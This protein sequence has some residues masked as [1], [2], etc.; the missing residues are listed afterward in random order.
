MKRVLIMLNKYKISED[1]SGIGLRMLEI[2]QVLARHCDVTICSNSISDLN[3]KGVRFIKCDGVEL[4]RLIDNSDTVVSTDLPNLEMLLYSYKMGKQ[5]IIENSIPVEHLFYNEVVLS[6]NPDNTYCTL[7]LQFYFQLMI[8]DVVIARSFADEQTLVP[9]L[10]FAGRINSYTYTNE[11]QLGSLICTIPIGFNT[12]SDE[13][14][15]ASRLK[16]NACYPKCDFLW[17]GGVWD[18]LNPQTVIDALK[19][20]P[21]TEYPSVGF[22]YNPPKDQFIKSYDA[23]TRRVEENQLNNVKFYKDV[24]HTERD[25][26]IEGSKALICIGKQTIENKTCHRLRLRDC[27][28]YKKPIIVDRY[29]ATGLFVQ[30]N[31][32]GITV[33]SPEELAEAMIIILYDKA[34]YLEYVTAI[35]AIR[36]NFLIENNISDLQSAILSGKK[37]QDIKTDF[38]KDRINSFVNNYKELFGLCV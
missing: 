25:M 36:N 10:A 6:D 8:A 18:Y 31:N 19:Y 13:H 26:Y 32:I 22:L 2:A 9:C 7:L 28:L 27:L 34:K 21:N 11:E 15:N 12:Y 5:I 16:N 4:K 23:L 14:R 38:M 29:G 37:A 3:C 20:F 33:E 24:A 35:E 1:M 30:A 17:S